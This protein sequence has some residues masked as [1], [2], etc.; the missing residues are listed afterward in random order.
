VRVHDETGSRAR[1]PPTL[2]MPGPRGPRGVALALALSSAASAAAR[3][4]AAP[5]PGDVAQRVAA[6]LLAFPPADR[7]VAVENYGPS[8]ALAA[9][10]DAAARWAAPG[11][12]ASA[13]SLLDAAVAGP[14]PP[15]YPRSSASNPW[16]IAHNISVPYSG[17]PGDTIGL[18]PIAFLARARF[19]GEPYAAYALDWQVA[20]DVANSY[21]LSYPQRLPDGTLSRAQGW[22]G[23]PANN[24][25]TFVWS[26]DDFMGLGLLAA[27]AVAPGVPADFAARAASFV[28]GEHLTFAAH[29]QSP[30]S[31][32]YQHGYNAFTNETSCCAWGRANG[33]HLL[34]HADVHA[35]VTAAAPGHPALPAL[36]ALWQSHAAGMLAVQPAAGAGGD[37]RWRQV[38][39]APATFLETSVTAMAVYSLARGIAAGVLDDATYGAAVD[40]AWAGVA[41]A[42]APDGSVA[43][44]C[45]GTG[46]GTDVAFYEARS[47]AY[48]TSDPGI[49]SVLRAAIAYDELTAWR[50]AAAAGAGR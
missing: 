32:L 50:A 13:S 12:A 45:E 22:A 2:K 42:V 44:I 31:G 21:V 25:S 47:T 11:L 17:T 19:R 36:R 43:G 16:N 23:Q 24:L 30:A 8:I 49:G 46:V 27:L 20:L 48:A 29:L 35:A 10:F 5:A 37:G 40:A 33:W 41:G 7:M 28:A 3:A 39:D 4:P 14:A 38:L 9:T 6:R 26:D 15:A 18:F 1:V 34:A